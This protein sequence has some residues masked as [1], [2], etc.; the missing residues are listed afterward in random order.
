VG[1]PHLEGLIIELVDTI[2][3]E[4]RVFQ[5]L[6]D[7]LTDEQQALLRHEPQALEAAVEVQQ[8]LTKMAAELEAQRSDVVDRLSAEMDEDRA[9]LT[10]KRL[11]DRVQ[12]P[13]ADS[14]REMRETL[15]DLQDRIQ[16]A[17]R[18]N[19]VLIRQSMKYVEK[20]LHLLTGATSSSTG[21][22]APTGKATGG[23]P[24]QTMVDQ[25]A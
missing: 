6:L 16:R 8:S 13:Q 22:Y 14:L 21:A 25:V 7:T 19:A 5:Q 4:I 10:L 3:A 11:V 24:K 23:S 15:L 12:G 20:S 18:H 1:A 2:D 9:S 17:N